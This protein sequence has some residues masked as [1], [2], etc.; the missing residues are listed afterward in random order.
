MSC[1]NEW[2]CPP[3]SIPYTVQAGDTLYSLA[4]RFESSVDRIMEVNPTA[5]IT[6]LRIGSKLCIPLPLQRYPMC[7]TTNYYVVTPDD[8]VSEIADYFGVST[9][10]VLYSNIGIDSENIYEG[11]VLCIP[12]AAPPACLSVDG[13]VLTVE[14][15]RG[16]KK[17]FQCRNNAQ[18]MDADIVQKQIVTPFEGG[19]R[20]LLS[21]Y[22]TVITGE[23]RTIPDSI[24]L[25][26]S[27]MDELFNLVTVGTGVDID[28]GVQ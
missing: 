14:F 16:G 2:S 6:N 7:R 28:D 21:D 23:E 13:G 25:S 19:K 24:G 12:V 15:K 3:G 10:Q 11:M 18:S 5:E 9:Q 22:K 17:S 27:D 4:R 20:L 1:F 8:T 26:N